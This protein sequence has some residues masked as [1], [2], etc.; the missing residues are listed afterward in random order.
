[1]R[2]I[3]CGGNHQPA[4]SVCDPDGMDREAARMGYRKLNAITGVLARRSLREALMGASSDQDASS[5]SS[6]D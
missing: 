2:C 5:Q 6:A 3:V 4:T 1:M